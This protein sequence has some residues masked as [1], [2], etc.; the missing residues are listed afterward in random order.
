MFE[1]LF[2]STRRL[3]EYRA[4]PLV[5]DRIRYLVHC[6]QCG[7][8]DYTLR[9]IAAHQLNLCRLLDL[10]EDS[11]VSPSDVEAAARAWSRPG[12]RN[13]RRPARRE[14]RQ[15]FIGHAL[16]WLRFLG[17]LVEPDAA[18]HPHA[19]EVEGFLAWTR[20]ACGW[21]ENTVQRI[22]YTIDSFFDWLAERGIALPS[23]AVSD[24]DRFIARYRSSGDYSR[25][26]IHN[27]AQDLRAFF[28]F[29]E[30]RNWCLRGIAGGIR[31][32]ADLRR[33]DDP[34]EAEPGGRSASAGH[35]RGRT[36][37]GQARPRRPHAADHLRFAWFACRRSL[38][39]GTR[40]PELGRRDGA[41][42]LLQTPGVRT[43]TRYP[44][45]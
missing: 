26:T 2:T 36:T 27:Y 3:A 18:R 32:T 44:I 38:W 33:R 20:E 9:S 16:R 34:C 23:V 22:R 6:A 19:A 30:Q 45:R 4:A 1:T 31:A 29:A 35:H 41:C 8:T 42:T 24:V 37:S 40:R 5:E 17:R 7:E 28:R 43:F 13:S 15:R 39:P 25:V 21:S 12:G 14:A 10:H 11:E